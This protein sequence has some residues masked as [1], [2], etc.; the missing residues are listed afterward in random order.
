MNRSLSK[1]VKIA[2]FHLLSSF[3]AHAPENGDLIYDGFN[4]MKAS[5]F[6]MWRKRMSSR[7]KACDLRPDGVKRAYCPTAIWKRM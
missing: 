1:L 4:N 3:W 6:R 2:C 5:S 7:T